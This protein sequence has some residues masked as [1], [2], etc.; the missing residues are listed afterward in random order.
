[1][2]K[3]VLIILMLA[4][5]VFVLLVNPVSAQLA[6]SAWPTFHG[7][8][9]RTGL[10]PYDTSHVDGTI[11]WTFETGS[12]IESSP[13]IDKEGTL[14]FGTTDCYVYAVDR[15]GDLKWK[16]KIGTPQ[17]KGYGG[18]K[19]Y[20]CIPGTASIDSNGNIYIT[21][22]DQK[23][24]AV[25]SEGNVLWEFIINLTPDHFGSPAIGSDGT[26]YVL[27]SPPDDGF[28]E[29][30]ETFGGY[31][32]TEYIKDNPP[33]GGLYA[34]N[35]DGTQK[36]HY[37]VDY[38]MFNSP[39]MDKN[40]LIYIAVS[41][42]Y[43]ERK[44]IVLKQ[45]G[46]VAWEVILPMEVESS[47]SIA[48]DGTVYIGSFDQNEKGS[49][50]FSINKEGV[51]WHYTLG[52]KEVFTTPAIG[53][54]GTVYIGS[55]VNKIFAINPDGTEKWNVDVG[56][57]IESSIAVGAD[58]TIYFGVNTDAQ[59]KPNIFALNPDGTVKWSYTTETHASIMATPAIGS[60]GTVYFA[61]WDGNLYAFGSSEDKKEKKAETG[62]QTEKEPEPQKE[63][64]Q[65]ALP[66]VSLLQRIIGWFKGLFRR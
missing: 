43:G 31:D 25:D 59:G 63:M 4:V 45:D 56:G 35:P 40:G 48:E 24:V 50:L 60:D 65:P 61:P 26:I 29:A 17:I 22:R 38:R 51:K 8:S 55:M 54:D 21:T 37:N 18:S 9:Q 64:Q 42:D 13:V 49:G 36:W 16:T 2:K 23:L 62:E 10:S 33:A 19:D 14:Y 46:T 47:P 58:G 15:Q 28:K 12:G 41:T 39:S 5:L 6:D 1:M 20:T 11:L 66:E 44:L 27:G 52:Q 7:N 53:G 34:L 30:Y 32:D 57:S 3:R